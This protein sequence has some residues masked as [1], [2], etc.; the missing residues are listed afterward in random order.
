[1]SCSGS[2][3]CTCGCCAGTSAQTPQLETNPPL[4]PAIAYRAGTWAT[5]KESMLARLS[6]A[7]YPALAALKTRDDDDFTVAFLDATAVMLD[8][9]TFYQE[10]L[11]NESYLRT[12]T[13]LRSLTELSRLIGY[14]PAPGIAAATYLAFT[15][16]TAPGLPPNPS[17]PP[18]TIPVGTQ[19]QSVPT[20][21][22]APQTFETVGAIPAKPDWNALPVQTGTPWKPKM[23]DTFV[24]LAGTATQLNPGDLFLI[25]GDERAASTASNNWD[26]RLVTSVTPDTQNNRTLVTWTEGLGDA[27]AGIKPAQ[28][29]P[30]FYA[31]RQRAA[32][33]GY[34]AANPSMLDT[35]HTNIDTLLNSSHTEWANFY[36][37][38]SIDLDSSYP[39]VVNGSWLAMILP[40]GDPSRNPPGYISLYNATS[41]ATLARSAYA[42]SA[43]ITR[44]YPDLTSNLGDYYLRDTSVF[45]QSDQVAV[46]E[47][48]LDHPFYGSLLDLEIL[49]P[50]LN[51]STVIALNGVSQKISVN[52]GVGNLEF[53]PDDPD[54]PP[55]KLNPGDIFTV[56]NPAPLP[57]KDG[58]I[59]AWSTSKLAITIKAQD[60]NGRPGTL[61][62][63]G[64]ANLHLSQFALAPAGS[65]D[66]VVTEYAAVSS[67]VEILTPFPHTQLQLASPVLNTYNRAETTVNINVAPATAGASVTEIMG[68]GS[69]TTPDQTFTLR[70]TPLTY[71]QAA[72]PNGRQ[73]TLQ[74][75]ANQVAWTEVPTLY[76]QS[77]TAQ[78]FSTINEY[79]ATTDVIFGDGVEG[80]TLPT[81][82]NNIIAN[83]RIGSGAAGNVAPGAITTLMQRP[84]GVSGVTNPG[85]A[86]GGQDP[87]TVDGIRTNA[88]QTVLTLGRAVS[89]VDYQNYAATFAGI[90]QANAIWIP[91]GPFRGV[92]LTVAAVG[93][94]ALQ[95][96]NLTLGYLTASLQNYGNPLI[97]IYAATF[98]ETLFDFAASVAYDPTFSQPAVETQIMA[99]LNQTYGFAN[100][101]FAEGVS[102]EQIAAVIQGVPGVV[103]VNVTSV[104]AGASSTGGDLANMNGGF[105]V[106]NWQSWTSQQVTVPRQSSSSATRICPYVPMASSQSLPI[107]AEI[108]VIDPNPNNILLTVMS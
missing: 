94:S 89:L 75:K 29:H 90:T 33:F 93:G 77:P 55:V 66:P 72:T 74:V 3:E 8:I 58:I 71:V 51:G 65:S 63:K 21:G 96:G 95:P 101:T 64:T 106:S 1:M 50:D 47:Q 86:T 54:S 20:Q 18:I 12:A 60:S 24:Y 68:N 11:A 102:G 7:D 100:R 56:T 98:V 70:Q 79:D 108:L 76:E 91:S 37:T 87:Q 73:S 83:Y 57:V 26:I 92:F 49:R 31:F 103:A 85:P 45:A 97:P 39:K 19:A 81:G 61:Q 80:A 23:N 30:K 44:V 38:S 42:L 78:E 17:T 62:G 6:S 84:I 104:T 59:P 32:L 107:A 9:L 28:Q 82:Q 16:K 41:V 10:R 2:S 34:N 15:L 53:V 14:Q 43:K 27:A 46:A 105:T 22:Q 88:P 69:A 13:Q 48:P 67:V 99:T 35:K 40:D 25:V 52:A 4:Q 5:F 36:L